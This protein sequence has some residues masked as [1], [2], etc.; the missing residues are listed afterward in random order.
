M[1][2][3]F[4]DKTQKWR[5][6]ALNY[7]APQRRS[8]PFENTKKQSYNRARQFKAEA[9]SLETHSP[10]ITDTGIQHVNRNTKMNVLMHNFDYASNNL[11]QRLERGQKHKRN[12]ASR[13]RASKIF[14]LLTDGKLKYDTSNTR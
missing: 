10:Y 8:L 5:K 7:N 1:T 14:E 2:D 11:K 6:S 3:L 9:R 12:H 13:Y 4:T